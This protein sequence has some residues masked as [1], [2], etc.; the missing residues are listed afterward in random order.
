S[1][2]NSELIADLIKSKNFKIGAA[3]LFVYGGYLYIQ[4]L[5][6]ETNDAQQIERS[7]S[8]ALRQHQTATVQ[9]C[10]RLPDPVPPPTTTSASLLGQSNSWKPSSGTLPPT[11]AQRLDD[12]LRPNVPLRP[13]SEDFW[14]K[15]MSDTVPASGR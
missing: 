12:L 11:A 15:V 4:G 7:V 2:R 10:L 9:P 1:A 14:A 8:A 5:V 13:V 3:A 6:P